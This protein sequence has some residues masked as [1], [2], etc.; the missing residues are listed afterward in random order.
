MINREEFTQELVLRE[1]IR[2]AIRIV[3]GKKDLD[4]AATRGGEKQLRELIRE[5][6]SEAKKIATYDNTGKNELNVFLLN[7]SFLSTLETSYR[8]M[9]TSFEQRSSYIDHMAAAV[10]DFLIRLDSLAGE[11]P[12]GLTEEETINIDI[13]E[14]PTDDP[15]FMGDALEDEDEPEKMGEPDEPEFKKFFLKGRD[16]T[17]AKNA[18]KDFSNV[19]DILRNAYATLSASEDKESFREELP[20]QIILY[21]KAW[22]KTLQPEVEVSAETEAAAGGGMDAPEPAEDPSEDIASIE[23]QELIKHLNVDDII[24]NLL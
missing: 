14:D 2:K 22:E 12:I 6:I 17:G 18:F 11:D 13:D 15:Q 20:T 23:L 9:T 3:R 24:K 16:I 7:S 19:Q 1:H 5:L 21:G 4:A 10:T 8:K